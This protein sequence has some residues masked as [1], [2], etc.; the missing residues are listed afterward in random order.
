MMCVLINLC[1]HARACSS[2]PAIIVCVTLAAVVAVVAVG[3]GLEGNPFY[4]F[5]KK[6]LQTAGGLTTLV[7]LVA[8]CIF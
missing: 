8:L 7:A 2:Q 5:Y 4:P 3:R 1:G 6:P